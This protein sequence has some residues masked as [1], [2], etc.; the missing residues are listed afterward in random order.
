[1]SS[2]D[3]YRTAQTVMTEPGKSFPPVRSGSTPESYSGRMPRTGQRGYDF[4]ADNRFTGDFSLGPVTADQAVFMALQASR[5]RA[6]ELERNN[7]HVRKLTAMIKSNVIGSK[8]MRFQSRAADLVKGT[9][10]PDKGAQDILE[11]RYEDYS[12]KENFSIDH[13]LSRR[14][15]EQMVIVRMVVDGECIVRSIRGA[16][17]P[18]LITNQIIDADLLD[19]R[20]NCEPNPRIGRGRIIMGIEVDESKGNRP[21]AYYFRKQTPSLWGGEITYPSPDQ[22]DRVPAEE[23]RHIYEPERPGQTRGVTYLAAGGLRAKILDGLEQA[24]LIGYRVAASKMGFIVTGDDFEGEG[25]KE[26][27]VPRD[28]APGMIDILPKGMKFENFDPSYPNADFEVVKKSIVQEIA[29]SFSVS[30]PELANDYGTINYSAG[31]LALNSD[32]VLW[33]CMAAS[34]QEMLAKP[35]FIDWLHMGLVFG[36]LPFPLNRERKYQMHRWRPAAKRNLDRLKTSNSQRIDLGNLS[37][38]PYSIADENGEDLD[39][40]IEGFARAR[41]KLREKDLPWPESWA[42]GKDLAQSVEAPEDPDSKEEGSPA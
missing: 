13:R 14:R 4:A 6:R 33:A 18:H 10:E 21:I 1:M 15:F 36:T 11:R 3:I 37:R 28:V 31:Q 16:D 30:Y 23:I 7:P 24:V 20:L 17:N 32:E 22:Y 9:L 39:E 12:E 26:K 19:H 38:S 2:S 35:T 29:A 25:V 42:G 8:P 34:L 40:V 5:N 41:D 27:D